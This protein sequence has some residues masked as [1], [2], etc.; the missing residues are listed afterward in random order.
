MNSFYY[1]HEKLQKLVLL[2]AILLSMVILIGNGCREYMWVTSVVAVL[3]L[4]SFSASLYIVIFPQRLALI[5]DE[6]IKIDHNAK[7]KWDDISKAE[8]KKLKGCLHR[9]IILIRVKDG[10]TYRRSFMQYFSKHSP[11]GEFSIPLY[12]MTEED[13]KNITSEISKHIAIV[14]ED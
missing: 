5:D 13:K 14:S 1:D 7:L 8:H 2:N 10:V 4:I 9:E 12:A 3:C 6:G 11:Y